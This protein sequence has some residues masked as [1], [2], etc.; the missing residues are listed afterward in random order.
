LL[1]E[2]KEEEEEEEGFIVVVFLCSRV[3]VVRVCVCVCARVCVVRG[4]LA[5][6]LRKGSK[7]ILWDFIFSQFT[8]LP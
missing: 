4:P 2:E 3:C 1:V 5:F 7:L 8:Q 6:V